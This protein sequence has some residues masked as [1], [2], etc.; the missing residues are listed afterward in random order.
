MEYDTLYSLLLYCPKPSR[1]C[2]ANDEGVSDA[3]GENTASSWMHRYDHTKGMQQQYLGW[4]SSP[5][6]PVTSDLS[7]GATFLQSLEHPKGCL[8]TVFEPLQWASDVLRSSG[9]LGEE[10]HLQEA[11]VINLNHMSNPLHLCF[12]D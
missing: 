6:R 1:K 11:C 12:H 7:C 8:Q 3:I 2:N 4:V 9:Q 5:C 10:D